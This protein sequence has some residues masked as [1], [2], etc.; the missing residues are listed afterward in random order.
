MRLKSK[1]NYG[2]VHLTQEQNKNIK[3]ERAVH[4]QDAIPLAVRLVV[5]HDAQCVTLTDD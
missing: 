3:I 1:H 4:C 2:R 5:Q